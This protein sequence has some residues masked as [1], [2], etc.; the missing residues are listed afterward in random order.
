MTNPVDRVAVAAATVRP[1]RLLLSLLAAPFYGLGF[2]IG[3]L[4]VAFT[5]LV[6]A[7]QVG[8]ADARRPDAAPIDE[9]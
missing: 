5:W 7:V 9:G 3:L 1:L 8:I 4:V 6:A 2:L